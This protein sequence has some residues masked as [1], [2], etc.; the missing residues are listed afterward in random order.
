MLVAAA[1][2]MSKYKS[3]SLLLPSFFSLLVGLED[4]CNSSGRGDLSLVSSG[5]AWMYSSTFYQLCLF[6]KIFHSFIHSMQVAGC[7]LLAILS[8]SILTLKKS[9]KKNKQTNKKKTARESENE[10]TSMYT[11]HELPHYRSCSQL[12]ATRGYPVE[13]KT[14]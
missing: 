12:G 3:D 8:M 6:N 10:A 13:H 2:S 1:F 14:S 7:R 5:A 9:K 11:L 4:A